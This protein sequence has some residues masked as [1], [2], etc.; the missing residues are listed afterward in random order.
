LLGTYQK[1]SFLPRLKE[2]EFV[3]FEAECN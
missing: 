2:V 3:T 1:V